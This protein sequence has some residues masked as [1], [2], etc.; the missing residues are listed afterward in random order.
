MTRHV[1]DDPD[2]PRIAPFRSVRDPVVRDDLG[3]FIAEGP[4]VVQEAR[5][6]G[7]EII[8]A[9]IDARR[10][11]PLD[12]PEATTVYAATPAVIGRITGLGVHRG[13]LALVRRPVPRTA[14]D[15]LDR[16]TTVVVLEAV[17]NPVNVGLVARSAAGLGADALLVDPTSGDPLYRRAVTA[18]R[19]ATLT[20]PFARIGAVRPLLEQ[21]GAQGWTTLALTPADDAPDLRDVVL[22]P[23]V[24]IVAG[25]EGFGLDPATMAAATCRARIPMHGGV[26]SLNIATATAIALW[27][28]SARPQGGRPLPSDPAP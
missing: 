24:A 28:I 2:D 14:D 4:D 17:E 26:D 10:E 3:A 23:R 11:A 8:S 22:A 1:V 6:C 5:R 27:A 21:L 13:V 20:L 25:S 9:M 12:L 15:V 7:L 16:A 18:S 19:A